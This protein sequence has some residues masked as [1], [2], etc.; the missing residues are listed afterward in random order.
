[1]AI[2]PPELS[3]KRGEKRFF[4]AVKVDLDARFMLESGVESR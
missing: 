3:A 2:L 4:T 1:M